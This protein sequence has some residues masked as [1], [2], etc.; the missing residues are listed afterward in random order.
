VTNIATR[1]FNVRQHK[2]D[3]PDPAFL[4]RRVRETVDGLAE[5]IDRE[6]ERRRREGLPIHVSENGRIVDLQKLDSPTD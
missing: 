3:S 1:S 6:V 2:A 4:D 5:A